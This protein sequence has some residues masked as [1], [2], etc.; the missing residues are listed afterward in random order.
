MT[1]FL[2][3]RAIVEVLN[4]TIGQGAFKAMVVGF[5][6]AL[7]VKARTAIYA[8]NDNQ[9]RTWSNV[10]IVKNCFVNSALCDSLIEFLLLMTPFL[11]GSRET[12]KSTQTNSNKK[13][14]TN[15]VYL[16]TGL[17]LT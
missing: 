14:S 2:S 6:S 15:T 7:I 9:L 1:M 17:T 12:I 5:R 13:S 3:L 4:K 16:K 10:L 8:R 11:R